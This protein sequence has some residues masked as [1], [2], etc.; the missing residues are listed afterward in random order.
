MQRIGVG[1]RAELHAH[2]FGRED[3]ERDIARLE[4]GVVPIRVVDGSA[5][6]ECLA[7]ELDGRFEILRWDRCEVDAGHDLLIGHASDPTTNYFR[8]ALAASRTSS[9]AI[10]GIWQPPS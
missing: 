2:L 4:L 8:A 9:D 10:R 7:V 6:P 1:V 3:A 5:Q